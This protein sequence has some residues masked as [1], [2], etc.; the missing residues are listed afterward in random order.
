MAIKHGLSSDEINS[1]LQNDRD[2]GGCILAD[3]LPNALTV[4]PSQFFIINYS[5]SL[6]N[7]PAAWQSEHPDYTDGGTHWCMIRA[8]GAK[9]PEFY[10][11]FGFRP[12]DNAELLHVPPVHWAAWLT[13][14]AKRHGHETYV[15]N[16]LEMQCS[17][18]VS[19]GYYAII[20]AKYGL[21]QDKNGTIR[22]HVWKML[23]AV[24]NYCS[25]T[26]QILRKVLSL[27]NVVS[28]P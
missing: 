24:K 2:Y 20:A 4:V 7:T 23:W 9:P 10:D 27:K 12:G 21:P 19:C 15:Y 1:L 22:G 11:S 14:N 8:A 25:K 13:S 26:D 18:Q 5:T 3:Q 28:E 6:A 16:S 17:K